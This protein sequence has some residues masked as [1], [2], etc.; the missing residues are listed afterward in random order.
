MKARWMFF[1]RIIGA[2]ILAVAGYSAGTSL[3]PTAQLDGLRQ[4]Q[5]AAVVNLLLGISFSLFGAAIGYL[6]TPLVARPLDA[7]FKE[8][9]ELP[10]MRLT[11]AAIGMAIGLLL[12]ALIAYPLSLLPKPF[13]TF[14]PVMS[15]AALAYIGAATVGSNPG[16]YLGVLRSI[17]GGQTS[18]EPGNVIL[19][20]TS[21]IIDGRITDVAETGF[22]VHT[23]LVPR[24]VLSELQQ[25]AD[26]SDAMR[27]HRGRRGLDVLNQ[28]QSSERV[29]VEITEMDV[30]GTNEVDRKLVGLAKRLNC[31]VMT[32]DYN[33]NRVAE[34]EGV[35]VLNLNEL[36]NAVK[37]L[38]LPGERIQIDVIQEGKESGQGVGY[39]D[40][41]TMVVVESGREQIGSTL[42]VAVT[43]VLQTVAGRMVFAQLVTDAGLEHG[44]TD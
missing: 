34:I 16:A 8:L 35:R 13:G 5:G 22:I 7:V 26:S 40:D 18:S 19:V 4:A 38:L 21:V 28:L 3:S 27:R 42:T 41:G 11:G 36:A 17:I 37:T 24:F 29:T 15:A 30:Q 23:L 31:A 33:L 14:F 10:P 1:A 6:S 25:V 9:R 32:N 12:G 39:L 2:G 20:D 44:A 43:R